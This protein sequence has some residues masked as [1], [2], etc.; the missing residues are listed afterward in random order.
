MWPFKGR[1][2]VPVAPSKTR[3]D[4][5]WTGGTVNLVGPSLE[6]R[7]IG[8]QGAR[9]LE[10]EFQPG[11]GQEMYLC[12]LEQGEWAQEYGKIR[13]L[14]LFAST[15]AINTDLGPV[16]IVLWRLAQGSET[17]AVYEHYLDPLHEPTRRML[18]R[19]ETQSRLKVVMRDN[20]SGETTGFWEFD[21]NYS[22][23]DFAATVAQAVAGMTAGPFDQR[24]QL[25]QR[26]Y[27][28]EQLM[29]LTGQS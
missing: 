12:I 4:N 6:Q 11:R 17:K 13:A 8:T 1:T 16:G 10:G 2:S 25:V 28:I 19:V 22:M 18:Q 7:D 21:N 23:G 15:L 9:F 20:R 29:T 24:I 5:R 26:D 3:I 27:P 14:D